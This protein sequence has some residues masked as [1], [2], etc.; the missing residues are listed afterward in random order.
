MSGPVTLS[1]LLIRLTTATFTPSLPGSRSKLLEL[2]P[3]ALTPPEVRAVP[4]QVL[5]AALALAL[6]PNLLEPLAVNPLK[7]ALSP[8]PPTSSSAL[9]LAVSSLSL[10]S[11]PKLLIHEYPPYWLHLVCLCASLGVAIPESERSLCCLIYV[12]LFFIDL[13]ALIVLCRCNT[14]APC[15]DILR[16][17]L[18]SIAGA[19]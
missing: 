12:S 3:P 7:T 14:S 11:S 6:A 2:P 18:L 5:T 1:S 19:E 15:L 17:T 16:V 4:A 10:P 13:L 8:R 9:P